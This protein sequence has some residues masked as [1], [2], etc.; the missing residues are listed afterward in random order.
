MVIVVDVSRYGYPERKG[1]DKLEEAISSGYIVS[2]AVEIRQKASYKDC[3]E[4]SCII[5]TLEK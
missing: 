2:S 3:N 1:L 5:Y 4:T